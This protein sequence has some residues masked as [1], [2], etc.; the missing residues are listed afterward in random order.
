MLSSSETTFS[1][2]PNPGTSLVGRDREIAEVRE[3]LRVARLVTLTGPGGTGKTRLALAVAHE[4]RSEGDEVILVD[5]AALDDAGLVMTAILAALGFR[6]TAEQSP[7][8]LLAARI[9]ARNVT[10]FL[11][12]FEHVTPAA[13]LVADLLGRCQSLR[14]LVTS[15][16]RLHLTLERVY[17]VPPLSIP[18]VGAPEA[19]LHDYGSVRLFLDRA[20]EATGSS[21]TA[22]ID[23]EAVADVCRRLEGLPLAIELAASRAR[24]L[25]IQALYTRLSEPL[26][27]LSGGPIDAPVRH[28][29]MRHTIAWSYDLLDPELAACFAALGVF[30]GD[31]SLEAAHAVARPLVGSSEAD[32][33]DA[34]TALVDQ[35]LLKS[36]P[37]D[38]DT[39]RF[40]M[41][42]AI[43]DFAV[44]VLSDEAAARDRHLAYYLG[45]AEKADPELE[46]AE[47]ARWSHVLASEQENLRAALRWAYRSS[48]SSDLLRLA[49]ALGSFWHWHGD[50]REGREWLSRA[51]LA[52]QPGQETLVAKAQRR[53]ALIYNA[54]GERGQARLMLESARLNAAR[55][56][57]MDGISQAMISMGG[58]LIDERR[59]IEAASTIEEGL[60]L[61]RVNGSPRILAH[62]ILMTAVLYHSQGITDQALPLY[63]QTAEIAR[64]IGDLR[65]AAVA[66][67]NLAD[68]RVVNR[69]YP[70]A[71]PLLAEGI[72]YLEAARDLAY[73]PWAQLEL[74][75]AL[76]K[77]G[78][79]EAARTALEHGTRLALRLDSPVELI[80]AAEV[81][82]DWLGAAGA[83]RE[84]LTA[85]ATASNAREELNLPRQPMDDAWINEGVERDRQA[86]TDAD[87][88]EAWGAARATALRG[89][90]TGALETLGAVPLDVARRD[91]DRHGLTRREVEVLALLVQGFGDREIA[92]TLFISP[93]T[94]SVHIASIK[95]KLG[96]GSRVEIVTNAVRTGLVALPTRTDG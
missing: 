69:D 14:A 2:Y 55:A 32:T 87:A 28:R 41:H 37:A 62:A 93:K 53:A 20:T 6:A 7:I 78:R 13:P 3:L 48:S 51:V 10:L 45:L 39:V 82:A 91:R 67:V 42:D 5:L 92:E 76:R 1:T 34:L 21:V 18:P 38:D 22:A 43:S 58:I 29:A 30:E 68:L 8:D 88:T 12:N 25:S 33:L 63:E 80:F 4:V 36:V 84:A 24:H 70:A 71:I 46:G 94:A 56:D 60:R 61:A 16:A 79:M 17:E 72:Q 31:F 52:V 83:H 81:L 96:A 50:L 90:V 44:A 65:M 26:P 85:W 57:D 49:A 89:A 73:L 47:Q 86:L 15:R 74:G 95:D 23:L 19:S 35:S 54:L 59:Q 66:L 77:V 64:G 27:I 11:D 75:L 40:V 9:A